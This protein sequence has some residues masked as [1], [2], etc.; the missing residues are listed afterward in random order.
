MVAFSTQLSEFDEPPQQP[1]TAAPA[2]ATQPSQFSSQLALVQ[3]QVGG[4]APTVDKPSHKEWVTA[5]MHEE[6]NRWEGLEVPPSTQEVNYMEYWR[7]MPA[8]MLPVLRL[9]AI[10][11]FGCQVGAVPSER[12]WSKAKNTVG[13]KRHGGKPIFENP[14]LPTKIFVGN[15]I[16]LGIC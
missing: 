9:M 14:S 12:L 6:I 13:T 15:K 7:D 5:R 1:E 2:A 11:W 4:T 3:A 16:W 8:G 10:D